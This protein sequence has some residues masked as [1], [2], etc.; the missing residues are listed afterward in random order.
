[1]LDKR[2]SSRKTHPFEAVVF[3]C[4]GLLLDTEEC[5]ARGETAFVEE[6]GREYTPEVRRRLLGVSNAE[7][8]RV[9]AHLL[10]RPGQG[11]V[12]ARELLERCWNM[13]V[14]GA[15]PRP[16][17]EELVA[18]LKGRVS[19][20][21]ASNSPGRLVREALA[22]AGMDGVFGAI[23]G[24]DE[25]AQAKPAPDVYLAACER[26]GSSPARSAALEDSP[27]GVA[28][29]RSAGLH[30]I[31][32]PS[33]PDVALNADLVTGSLAHPEVWR[34]LGLAWPSE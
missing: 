21:V 30:V 3:D 6:R 8:G 33:Q 13:V 32:V 31:G 28:A 4:D 23:V 22:I 2:Q 9:L 5:W 16:G 34:A 25:V 10:D 17:A 20:G 26:L 15:R 12:L 27:T 11:A 29:A 24:G 1:V 14:E 19:L 7:A 18:A